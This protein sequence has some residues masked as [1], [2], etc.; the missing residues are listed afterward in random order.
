MHKR[1]FKQRSLF[2]MTGHC[3]GVLND[4]GR[5]DRG[6]PGR[7][8]CGRRRLRRQLIWSGLRL[9]PPAVTE[10]SWKPFQ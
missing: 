1:G 5:A 10:P 3:V 4:S 9:V 7:G 6:A 8:R 2:G